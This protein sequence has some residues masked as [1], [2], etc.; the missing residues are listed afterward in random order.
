MSDQHPNPYP[1][2]CTAGEFARIKIRVTEVLVQIRGKYPTLKSY[3][4]LS[5][6]TAQCHLDDDIETML[7]EFPD[8]LA[9]N[10]AKHHFQ[11]LPQMPE[12]PS[13]E[14]KRARYEAIRDLAS[15][16]LYHKSCFVELRFGQLDFKKIWEL[17]TD[18]LVDRTRTTASRAS[19]RV[20][21]GAL[22]DFL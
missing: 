15:E 4:V 21:L 3:A 19:I 16:V 6:P 17:Q 14:E 1:D 18:D 10:R 7:E 8:L 20:V 5:I 13:R 11:N 9:D 2:H 12:K 22:G